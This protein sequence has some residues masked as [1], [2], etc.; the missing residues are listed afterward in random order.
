MISCPIG[1]ANL[2]SVAVGSQRRRQ[3]RPGRE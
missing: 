3:V 2:D 1:A